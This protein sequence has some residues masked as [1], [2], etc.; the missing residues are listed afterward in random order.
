MLSN[1]KILAHCPLF[2]EINEAD[3]NALLHCFSAVQK[4]YKKNQIIF[5]A[6]DLVDTVG[7][8]LAGSVHVVQED[9]WGN[10]TIL[11]HIESSGLFG[12]AFSCAE[13]DRIPVSVVAVQNSDILM[14]DYRKI[15]RTCSSSCVFHTRL[16]KNMLSIL[17]KKNVLLTQ[18]MELLTRRTTREKI[19]SY[20]SAQ[21]Q[22][23]GSATFVIPFNRQELANYLSVDRSALSKELSKMQKDGILVYKKNQFE[24][25]RSLS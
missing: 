4:Q 1:L 24:L 11:A 21:A 19:L 15:I 5:M 23:A 20:L 22:Q 17:A 14:I 10:Q 25:L 6:D 8:V 7:I 16:I 12:E 9:F 2:K 13:L 3:L 18:K